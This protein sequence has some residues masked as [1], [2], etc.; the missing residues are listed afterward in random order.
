MALTSAQKT[1]QQAALAGVKAAFN[2]AVIPVAATLNALPKN[3]ILDRA[4]AAWNNIVTVM[5]AGNTA[6]IR[7]AITATDALVPSDQPPAPPL[8]KPDM[9]SVAGIQAAF[10][11]SDAFYS[12][13]LPTVDKPTVWINGMLQV[14]IIYGLNSLPGIGGTGCSWQW[15]MPAAIMAMQELWAEYDFYID[16]DVPAGFN[17]EGCKLPGL[18]GAWEQPGQWAEPSGAYGWFSARLWHRRPDAAG[19]CELAGYVY[20]ARSQDAGNPFGEIIATGKMLKP[21]VKY[22][23]GQHIKLNSRDASGKWLSDGVFEILL[24]GVVVFSDTAF[25]MRADPRAT[26]QSFFVNIFHGGNQPVKAP[27]HYRIGGIIVDNKPIPWVPPVIIDTG[28]RVPAWRKG[29]PVGQWVDVPNTAAAKTLPGRLAVIFDGDYSGLYND[30]VNGRVYSA[31]A[32]GH[33]VNIAGVAAGAHN[34]VYAIDLMTDAPAWAVLRDPSGLQTAD[35]SAAYWADGRPCGSHIY[36]AGQ[37][38]IIG[39]KP[40]LVRTQALAGNFSELAPVRTDAFHLDVNDWDLNGGDWQSFAVP[41]KDN[42]TALD[43]RTGRIYV[44]TQNDQTGMLDTVTRKWVTTGFTSNG[45]GYGWGGMVVDP[46]L[47][48]L[49]YDFG[50]YRHQGDFFEGLHLTRNARITHPYTWQG[51]PCRSI[52]Q[53][54]AMLIDEVNRAIYLVASGGDPAFFNRL[55]L[56]TW[57]MKNLGTVPQPTTVYNRIEHFPKLGGIAHFPAFGSNFRFFATE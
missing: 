12:P 52:D 2:A 35:L 13:G 57:T 27:I 53:Y 20:S 4:I 55:D 46:V 36:Y 11:H 24:D 1:Q 45:W 39:G 54:R 37:V 32:A 42:A 47:D 50:G 29:L 22:K 14:P 25:K 26:F 34:G 7:D 38:P 28:P 19:N 21:G 8:F 31:G 51:T 6:A 16:P 49:L 43:A 18:A 9:S 30:R 15:W 17:E 41:W 44:Q 48:E 56:N 40:V 33:S 23:L 3:D 10:W 5:D